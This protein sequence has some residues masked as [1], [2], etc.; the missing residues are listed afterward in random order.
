MVA[1]LTDIFSDDDSIA[2]SPKVAK[3]ITINPAEELVGDLVHFLEEVKTEPPRAPGL[4]ASSLWKTCPRQLLLEQIHAEF[5]TKE[6]LRAGSHMTFDTGHQLHDLMQNGYLGPAGLIWG[7]W[8]CLSCQ[9]TTVERDW[10]PEA[11]PVCDTP[12]RDEH[13][14]V[15][16]IVYAETF[17][18]DKELDYCGH[19]D[20]ILYKR[21]GKK[22]VFEFKTISKSQYPNLSSPKHAHIIQAH[23]YMN[24]LDLDEAVIAYW[25]KGSQCD[26]SRDGRG[27]WIA[28]PPHIKSFLVKF[29]EDLWGEM[30]KVIVAYHEAARLARELPVVNSDTVMKFTRVCS[31]ATCT[32]ASECNVSYFCFKLPK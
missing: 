15:R 16:N 14:G 5:I 3:K 26:W 8:K 30:I 32:L 29:D 2:I 4:H 27:S 20:G 22:R 10:M 18:R 19:C 31:S 9:K 6:K 24:A 11:C 25:D 17:I 13:D 12:R 7:D 23:A 21:G 1:E 28:G